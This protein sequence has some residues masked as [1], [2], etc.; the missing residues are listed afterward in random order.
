MDDKTLLHALRKL[1]VET[2]VFACM[3][4]GYEHDCGIHG[5]AIMREAAERIEG[6]LK[7]EEQLRKERRITNPCMHYR[8]DGVCEHF[9]EPGI[10][11]YC[12]EGPC[13]A[14]LPEG[15]TY[16]D[17]IKLSGTETPAEIRRGTELLAEQAGECVKQAILGGGGSS[18]DTLQS[19]GK[20]EFMRGGLPMIDVRISEKG[21]CHC[22]IT[23][24]TAEIVG[25][26]SLLINQYYSATAK[27]APQLLPGIRKYFEKIT[28]P[29]SPM[30]ELDESVEGIFV[31]KKVEK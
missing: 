26:F 16:G 27:T 21:I 8:E 13:S 31:T 2:G 5:C 1:K 6:L 4:C 11:S 15:L 9:S 24:T 18:V 10:T 20:W 12:V 22:T 23:G 14:Y 29:G 28:A 19:D 17:N 30:W 25:E 3:G 7:N